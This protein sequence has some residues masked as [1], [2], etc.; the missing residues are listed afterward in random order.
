MTKST[1]DNYILSQQAMWEI[2]Y[3]ICKKSE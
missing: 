2:D 1:I 3:R